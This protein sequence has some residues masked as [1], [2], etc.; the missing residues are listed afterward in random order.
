MSKWSLEEFGGRS[1]KKVKNVGKEK[2][3]KFKNKYEQLKSQEANNV[4]SKK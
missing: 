2:A 1:I 3:V 4:R